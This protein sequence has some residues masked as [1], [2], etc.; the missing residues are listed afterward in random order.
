M[1]GNR[2]NAERAA[3]AARAL[4]DYGLNDDPFAAITDLLTDVRHFCDSR[5]IGFANQDRLAND[6]FL[7]ERTP[8]KEQ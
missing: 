3:R 5:R 8:R 2:S 4:K 7:Y 6:H 1:F